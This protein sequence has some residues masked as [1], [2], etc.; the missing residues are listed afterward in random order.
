MSD[1]P[2]MREAVQMVLHDGLARPLLNV[3]GRSYAAGFRA[4]VLVGPR[5]SHEPPERP[6]NP[7]GAGGAR[8][9]DRQIMSPLL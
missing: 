1:G 3:T 5:T 8:T 4:A 7:G 6:K 9:H 2:D